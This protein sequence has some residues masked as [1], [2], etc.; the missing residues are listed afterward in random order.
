MQPF[1]GEYY[2]GGKVNKIGERPLEKVE[3][4]FTPDTDWDAELNLPRATAATF[5]QTTTPMGTQPK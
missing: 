4:R 5:V 2:N 1:S 3:M